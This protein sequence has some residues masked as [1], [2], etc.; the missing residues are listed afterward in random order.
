[1]PPLEPEAKKAYADLE[2]AVEAVLRVRGYEGMLVEY[3]TLCSIQSVDD[4]GDPVSD[5]AMIL[6]M[7]VG[8]DHRVMGLL[9]YAQAVLRAGVARNE[10]RKQ[11]D[12]ES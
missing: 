7:G 5:I 4:E 9:D 8:L 2:R 6:P 3:V 1:M 12:D 11:D 10:L